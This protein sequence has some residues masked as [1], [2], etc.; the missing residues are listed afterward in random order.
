MACLQNEK[1]K[2]QQPARLPPEKLNSSRK[3]GKTRRAR[4]P[5]Q[6]RWMNAA[7]NAHLVKSPRINKRGIKDQRSCCLSCS[8]AAS[9]GKDMLW[10]MKAELA[11]RDLENR[12][13]T[14]II[15]HSLLSVSFLGTSPNKKTPGAFNHDHT[16]TWPSGLWWNSRLEWLTPPTKHERDRGTQRDLCLENDIMCGLKLS[17]IILTWLRIYSDRC[18]IVSHSFLAHSMRTCHFFV[19][20]A[21]IPLRFACKIGYWWRR[22]RTQVVIK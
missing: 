19:T 11:Y 7:T 16:C 10:T 2:L 18:V 4:N 5:Q 12:C 17:V 6:R 3:S 1:N 9:L 8:Y 13:R 21:L 14:I 22:W 15:V 20:T